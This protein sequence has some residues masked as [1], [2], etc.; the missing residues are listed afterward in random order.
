M[1]E[2]VEGR[3]RGVFGDIFEC[4]PDLLRDEDTPKTVKGWDSVNH[5]Q[6]L[7]AVEETFGIQF[8]PEEFASLA[9]FGALRVRISAGTAA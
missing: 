4:D 9:S 6:L 2:D 3:L 1:I 5:M 7:L 8:Q